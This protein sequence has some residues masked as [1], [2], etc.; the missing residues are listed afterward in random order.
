MSILELAL[1]GQ[2]MLWLIIVAVFLASGQASIFHPLTVYLAFHGVVFVVRPILIRHLD[3]DSAFIYMLFSPS[4]QDFVKTL[5]VSSVALVIFFASCL[6][7]GK[8]KLAFSTATPL[9]FTTEQ[10]RALIVTT[11]ILAPIVAYSI[12]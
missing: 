2:L 4:E 8:T 12:A 6:P 9:P 3:F 1:V 7:A 11:V 10:K 5:A